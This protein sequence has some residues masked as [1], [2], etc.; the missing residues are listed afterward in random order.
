MRAV[1]VDLINTLVGDELT[2]NENVAVVE[3]VDQVEVRGHRSSHTRFR[4]PILAACS[5]PELVSAYV[6]S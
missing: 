1:Q 6:V 4:R 5:D 3:L 2:H